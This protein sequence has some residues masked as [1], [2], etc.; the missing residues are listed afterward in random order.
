M[1]KKRAVACWVTRGT[2]QRS[3]PIKE[4]KQAQQGDLFQALRALEEE[5]RSQIQATPGTAKVH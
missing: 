4:T 2:A 5:L 1:A 3:V